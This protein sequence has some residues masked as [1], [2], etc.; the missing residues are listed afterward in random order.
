MFEWLIFDHTLVIRH[1][2][3]HCHL[4][5]KAPIQKGEAAFALAGEQRPSLG[6]FPP[7][8]LPPYAG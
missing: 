6:G 2:V 4:T 3:E 5:D 7:A 1:Y 8:W